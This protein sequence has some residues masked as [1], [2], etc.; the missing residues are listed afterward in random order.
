MT[1]LKEAVYHKSTS[2]HKKTSGNDVLPDVFRRG[3]NSCIISDRL[4]RLSLFNKFLII[5]PIKNTKFLSDS[6][7]NFTPNGPN[8]IHRYNTLSGWNTQVFFYKKV[9]VFTGICNNI[10][11]IGKITEF[12]QLKTV[13]GTHSSR[14]LPDNLITK[15]C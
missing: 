5:C 3:E 1:N 12:F 9:T 14:D 4:S 13:C 10:Q 8:P 2:A 11:K 7:F 6:S 15:K